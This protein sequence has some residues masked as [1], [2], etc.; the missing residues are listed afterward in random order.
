MRTVLLGLGVVLI[1]L[2]AGGVWWTATGC[3]AELTNSSAKMSARIVDNAGWQK[4][5]KRELDCKYGFFWLK[6]DQKPTAKLLPVRK[7]NI[8]L[9]DIVQTNRV[10]RDRNDVDYS[11]G[12][13]SEG[14]WGMR[15]GIQTKESFVKALAV[16]LVSLKNELGSVETMDKAGKLADQ[17]DALI[18]V[19]Q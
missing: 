5:V 15:L 16:G 17:L 9:V 7:L 4:V 8:E 10:G 11:F 12:W 19:D 2:L 6:E 14:R 1:L 13:G 3:R 18:A